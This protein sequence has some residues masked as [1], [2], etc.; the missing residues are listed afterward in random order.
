VRSFPVRNVSPI[1]VICEFTTGVNY[2]EKKVFTCVV[3]VQDGD[4]QFQPAVKTLN[5]E[6]LCILNSDG[7][8]LR[9]KNSVA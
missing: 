6:S 8:S 5:N 4:P 3:T 1:I 9:T 2:T 7:E